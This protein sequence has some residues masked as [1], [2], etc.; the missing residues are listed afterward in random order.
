V[1]GVGPLAEARGIPV[2]LTAGELLGKLYYPEMIDYFDDEIEYNLPISLDGIGGSHQGKAAVTAML[3]EVF[4][5]FYD[6]AKVVPEVKLAFADDTCGT[7][8]FVM[9]A[10]L[11]WGEVYQNLYSITFESKDGKFVKIHEFLD[12]KHLMETVDTDKMVQS[13][14]AAHQPVAEL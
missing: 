5:H 1:Q 9:N 4:T 14:L 13:M 8:V 10:T 3:H 7:I 11:R 6:P 2:M 12:T